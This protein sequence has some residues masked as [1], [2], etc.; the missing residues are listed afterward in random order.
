MPRRCI[1]ESEGG[2]A[3]L[4]RC[5]TRI[6]G[7]LAFVQSAQILLVARRDPQDP[8]RRILK[9]AGYSV[10]SIDSPSGVVRTAERSRPALIVVETGAAT[11]AVIESLAT[12]AAGYQI[13][14][15]RDWSGPESL[16]AE[17][18][19]AL[20]GP[21]ADA[22]E[23]PRIT[24]G[25]LTLDLAAHSATIA[26]LSLD[27]TA[28]EFELLSHLA[29]HPGWVYTF[30]P[31]PALSLATAARNLSPSSW[32]QDDRASSYVSVSASRA[33]SARTRASRSRNF[34]LPS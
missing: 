29:R 9:D 5:G 12:F 8:V 19:R 21:P 1:I 24:A 28:R 23:T 20:G 13:P 31:G 16:L 33:A 26:G 14:L 6:G 25:P 17:I 3:A 22:R 34:S 27:L 15:V 18:E 2:V 30:T 7:C 32:A 10:V 11:A 4:G